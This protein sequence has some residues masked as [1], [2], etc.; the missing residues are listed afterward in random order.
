M[1]IVEKDV[2]RGLPPQILH[3]NRGREYGQH[4]RFARTATPKS[5]KQAEDAVYQAVT[6]VMLQHE[7]TLVDLTAMVDYEVFPCRY[8]FYV[9]IR[10][11]DQDR[12]ECSETLLKDALCRIIPRYYSIRQA[13]QLGQLA[14]W[15]VR[16]GTFEI[17]KKALIARGTSASQVKIPRVIRDRELASLLTANILNTAN[18]TLL[19]V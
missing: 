13:D 17:L 6:E 5:H 16:P 9:E 3:L 15:M 14:L 10:Y 4:Y 7:A 19:A 1:A 18:D 11:P 12:A 2:E 8:T